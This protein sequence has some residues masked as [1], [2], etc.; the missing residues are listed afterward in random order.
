MSP[1]AGT[2]PH[3]GTVQPGFEPVEQAF[4]EGLK[5][6][7]HGGGALAAYVDGK[8]VVD[9]WGGYSRPGVTWS[10]E[11][12]TVL[13]SSTKGFSTLCAQILVDRG[14][15][16]VDAPVTKYWP[17]FA[18]AGK[19]GVL[20]RH[21]LT[22]TS[23]VIGFGEHRPPLGWDGSGWDDYDTISAGLAASVPSWTPP[24]SQ[25]G[26]HALTYGWLLGEIVRR[27]TGRT[28]GQF[29]H[30]EVAVPLGLDIWIGTPDD[31]RPRV[32]QIEN[33]IEDGIPFVIRLF[34]KRSLAALADPTTM[35]GQAFVA[36]GEGKNLFD[37]ADELFNQ[38]R[39]LAAEIPAGGG[40]GTARS[41]ARLYSMLAEGGELDGVRIVSPE[42]VKRFAAE[43]ICMD[44]VLMSQLVPAWVRR[45][46]FKPVRRTLGYLINPTPLG[47]AKPTFGPNPNAYGHDGAGGQIA[48]CDP[49]RR[50]AV[51]FIRN[52]LISS[53]RFS[54]QL[55]DVLYR[56]VGAAAP[57]AEAA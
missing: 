21:V 2:M 17:E 11:T 40:T 43:E 57:Q 47:G 16:D 32:A 1:D 26:Y 33:H 51:G 3:A 15:L 30:D 52:D 19:E 24:G 28:I 7:G 13:M 29:F 53:P 37:H 34:F 6:F 35:P 4:V 20:V 5:E 27:I 12:T 9:L 10:A 38:G 18:Q 56:C 39:G 55:I 46:A 54:S 42:I 8:P 44:D 45:L 36:D 41:V 23:G 31:V 22:H 25:F 49:D 48:F 50:I 14:Q